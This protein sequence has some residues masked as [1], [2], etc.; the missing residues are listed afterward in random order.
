VTLASV[1]ARLKRAL[2]EGRTMQ[3]LDLAK[4]VYKADPSA[5]NHELLLDTYLARSRQLRSQDKQRDAA[6]VL[7]VAAGLV[8]NDAVRL[9]QIATELAACGDV[10]QALALIRDTPESPAHS[11]VLAQAADA[12]IRREASGRALLPPDLHADFDRIWQAFAQLEA[13]QDKA[14]RETLQGIGLRSAFLEWKLLLRG[15]QAYY[16]GDDARAIENWQRLS[17]DRLPARLAA[18]MRF[19]IDTAYR[20][21]QP[22]E[23][24]RVLQRQTDRLVDQSLLPQLRSIQTALAG[25]RGLSEAFRLATQVVPQ[26]R[27][28]APRLVPALAR[29]YYWAI[30][31]GGVPED[32]PRYLRLFGPPPDDPSCHRLCALAA[33]HVH[34]LEQ[35]HD[36]WAK[37]EQTLAD[38]ATAWPADHVK[39]VRALIWLHMGKNAAMVPDLDQLPE[40]PPFLRNHPDR[41]RPLKP[42]AEQCFKK[43]LKL[44]PDLLETHEALFDYLHARNDHGKTIAAGRQFLGRFPDHVGTLE[45]LADLLM[46]TEQYAEALELFERALKLHPLD[47]HLRSKLGTAHTYNARAHAE[48]GRF[49][50]AR[51]EYQAALLN[52]GQDKSSVL[53]KWAACEFKAGDAAR[54]E[55]LLS[56]ALSAGGNRLAVAFSMLIEAIRLKLPR[57]LKL[58]FDKEFKEALEEPVTGAIAA[59]AIDTAAAHAAAGV[60]YYGQKAHEKKVLTYVEKA[61][62]ATFTEEQLS[63]VC[64]GLLVLHSTKLLRAFC[65]LGAKRFPKAAIFPF[66]EAES[67]FAKGPQAL[68]DRW[69]I[70]PLIQ[71]AHRR[72][73]AMPHDERREQLL[74][75]IQERQKILQALGA[76]SLDMWGN[77]VNAGAFGDEDGDW[78][79]EGGW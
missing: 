14:A 54:A 23:A 71:K 6:S 41:P 9:G 26:V 70:E 19:G 46:A 42:S 1:K 78:D 62:R 58:R 27:D 59:A 37:Y 43:S 15:L 7:Q 69:K 28:Q 16:Q 73:S 24:Q 34:D 17:Q 72:A 39:R 44:A 79:D 68:Y 25:Q 35:A 63:R 36:S 77:L 10:A 55:E 74:E 45:S 29:C 49:D 33:E 47:R 60:K 22:P 5:A 21:A 12:A 76:A 30:I 65:Q 56:Q 51:A 50:E 32:V 75:Q 64:K 31:N 3:A 66:L 53:C 48:A 13:G 40:L 20:T 67:Y 18:P 61:K 57:P 11:Q 52:D 4:Q 8:G 38:N 2:Q